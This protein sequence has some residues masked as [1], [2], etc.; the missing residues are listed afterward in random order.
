MSAAVGVLLL[1]VCLAVVVK[2]LPAIGE[3]F[4]GRRI[5]RAARELDAVK[6]RR[7]VASAAGLAELGR[8]LRRLP[9]SELVALGNGM[10]AGAGEE[11]GSQIL[12]AIAEVV[13]RRN[14]AVERWARLQER[15]RALQEG[16]NPGGAG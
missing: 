15:Q 5:E 2:G 14:Q 16:E 4:E 3:A 13:E 7:A 10:V 1:V 8:V 6:L 11:R 9:T 12:A